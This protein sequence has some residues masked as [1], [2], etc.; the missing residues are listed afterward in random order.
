MSTQSVICHASTTE[1][2]IRLI[3]LAQL[4]TFSKTKDQVQ[5]PGSD[6]GKGPLAPPSSPVLASPAVPPLPPLLRPLLLLPAKAPVLLTGRGNFYCDFHDTVSSPGTAALIGSRLGA[7]RQLCR[8][9][10][11]RLSPPW[12][13]R[14]QTIVRKL[15]SRTDRENWR[16]TSNSIAATARRAVISNSTIVKMPAQSS[17]TSVSGGLDRADVLSSDFAALR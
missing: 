2:I 10:R 11:R 12:Q 17:V 14:R 15:T 4:S 16:S 3:E 7:I 9:P 1:R 5:G 6:N 13:G 8:L